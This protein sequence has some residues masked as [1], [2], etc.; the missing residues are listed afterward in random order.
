M[1]HQVE[2]AEAAE[3]HTHPTPRNYVNIAIVLAVITAAEVA[4]YYVEALESIL[5]PVLILFAFLKFFLVVSWFM[6][7]RFDS[8]LFRRLFVTGLI[9]AGL[10]FAVVLVTFFTHLGGP[11]PDVAG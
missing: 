5:V 10:V 7:L 11:T 6:H 2:P 9:L 8:K 3:L 4:I 1:S